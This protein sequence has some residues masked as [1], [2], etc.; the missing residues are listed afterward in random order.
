[1]LLQTV[2]ADGGG[3]V[4]SFFDVAGLEQLSRAVGAVR[5]D[6]GEAVRLQFLTH[7]KR[8]RFRFARALARGHG[9]LG[10]AEQRLHVMPDFMRDDVR[11]REVAGRAEPA[12]QILIEGQVDVD[13]AIAGTIERPDRGLGETARRLHGAREEHER[14][15][16]V[17]LSARGEDGAPRV[18]GIRE[19]E[20]DELAQLRFFRR[21]LVRHLLRLLLRR[22]RSLQHDRWIDAEIGRDECEHDRAEPDAAGTPE[23]HAATIFDVLAGAPPFPTHEEPP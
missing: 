20:R 13:L 3:G 10:N 14:G 4:E 12:L 5:P 9:A 6:S 16:L 15:L 22:L 11:L 1:M 2:V 19:H 7:G 17:G 18:L 21:F 23:A 8:V